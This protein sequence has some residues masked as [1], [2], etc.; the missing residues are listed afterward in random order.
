MRGNVPPVRAANSRTD[1]RLARSSELTLSFAAGTSARMLAAVTSPRAVLRTAS[2]TS[3]PRRASV[4]AQQSPSPLVAP[5]IT[6]MRP[7]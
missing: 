4:C 7:V 3:A 6:A 5:V 1:A 2:T